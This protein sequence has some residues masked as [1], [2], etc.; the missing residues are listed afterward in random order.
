MASE[1]KWWV[2][3]CSKG[4]VRPPEQVQASFDDVLKAGRSVKGQRMKPK[5]MRMM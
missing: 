4:G 2:L 5:P 1:W 3:I